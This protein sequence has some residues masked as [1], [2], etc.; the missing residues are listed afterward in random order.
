MPRPQKNINNRRTKRVEIRLTETEEKA[1]L[2]LAV[3]CGLSISDHIRKAALGA[4]PRVQKA[5]P[6]RAA[7][8]KGLAELGKIGSNVNQIAKALNTELAARQKATVSGDLINASLYAIQTLS[9]NL[10]KHLTNGHQG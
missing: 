2:E 8:I 4:K 7:F 6:E 5:T 1:L 3:E 10:I 9:K